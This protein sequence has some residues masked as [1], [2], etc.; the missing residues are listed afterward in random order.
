MSNF[1]HSSENLFKRRETILSRLLSN[2]ENIIKEESELS[3]QSE[4]ESTDKYGGSFKEFEN[5]KI[6]KKDNHIKK[7]TLKRNSTQIS[8][9]KNPSKTKSNSL[10]K[11]DTKGFKSELEKVFSNFDKNDLKNKLNINS[12][13]FKI[14]ASESSNNVYNLN[15][16]IIVK[17]KP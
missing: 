15:N 3:S 17:S 13:N 1:S 6:R 16:T 11:N 7:N 4:K 14:Q 10:N 12:G 9:D 8:N 5:D 2:D